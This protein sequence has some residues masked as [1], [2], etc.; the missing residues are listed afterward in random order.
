MRLTRVTTAMT[1]KRDDYALRLWDARDG[2]LV[3]EVA[4]ADRGRPGELAFTIY[5]VPG[6]AYMDMESLI[7]NVTGRWD[8]VKRTL[9]DRLFPH[10][11]IP[12]MPA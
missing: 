3:A 9:L 12:D 5:T 2:E 1:W 4:E 6:A 10:A 7:I 11:I 8:V